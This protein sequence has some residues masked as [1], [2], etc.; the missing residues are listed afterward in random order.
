MSVRNSMGALVLIG[1]GVLFGMVLGANCDLSSLG[2]A[3]ASP[4]K[5]EAAGVSRDPLPSPFV[6]IAEEISPSVVNIS[7]RATVEGQRELQFEGP[8]EEFFREFF[9][10]R[11]E[12][13]R[14]TRSRGSGF[15]VD[16]DGY[17]LT[18]YHVVQSEEADI[19]VVLSNE[20]RYDAE[21]VG[22]DPATDLA[23]VRIDPDEPLPAAPL[24]D[25]GDLRVGDWVAAIGNPFGLDRTLTHGVVSALGRSGLTFAGGRGGATRP[26]YQDYIQTDASINFGNSGGPLVNMRGE[27]IGVN[28]A[29]TSPSGGNVGIGFAIPVNIAK[30]VIA[31]LKQHGRVIRGWLGVSISELTP[32][33]AEGKGIEGVEGVLVVQ[34]IENSPADEAGFERGDVILSVDGQKVKT[35]TELQLL[36]ADTSVGKE[37]S[38]Q[39]VRDKKEKLLRVVLG[40]RPGEGQLTEPTEETEWPGLQVVNASSER[41]RRMG[42]QEEE[43]VVVVSVAGRSAAE[44]AGIRRG[45]VISEIQEEPVR[46]V[47]DYHRLMDEVG[48]SGKPAVVYLRRNGTPSYVAI[49]PSREGE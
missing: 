29:I 37:V 15:V 5:T 12:A 38:V 36:V 11:P 10:Y 39:I 25:S 24:G 31:D 17:I 27:V 28:A 46:D 43:G 1:V 16:A 23:L 49:R 21:V 41:A 45:D 7:A 13:E 18:N 6:T 42:V 40:E 19:V 33:I 3:T 9:R 26:A 44:E 34:V 4:S 20:K 48:A 35:P 32:D 8:F 47:D 30:H 14:E 2:G 22:L